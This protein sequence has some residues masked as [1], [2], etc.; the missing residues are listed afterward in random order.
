MADVSD[1]TSGKILTQAKLALYLLKFVTIPIVGKLIAKKL[2]GEIKSF[3]P[4]LIDI[5]TASAIIQG[6][7]KCAVGERVCRAIHNKSKLTESVFLDELAE[8]LVNIKKA[9]FV[10]KIEAI[11]RLKKYKSPIILSKVS[12]NNMEICCSIPS[13]CVYWN[14]EKRGIKCLLKE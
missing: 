2:S 5:E 7:E 10:S 4:K 1:Y 9:E 12:R 11:E 14:F 6:S 13:D 3:E 8:E